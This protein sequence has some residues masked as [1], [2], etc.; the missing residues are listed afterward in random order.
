MR[1]TV[2]RAGLIGVGL[3]LPVSALAGEE[4]GNGAAIVVTGRGLDEAPAS[5]A[6]DSQVLGRAEIDRAPSGRIEDVLGQVAGFQQFRRSDSRSTNPSAQGVTLRAL[7]GN[8]AARTLVLLDGVPLADPM[9]GSVPLAAIDPER[10]GAIRVTRGGGSGAFGAGA[11]AG[12]IALESADADTLGRFRGEVLV[13]DRGETSLSGGIAPKLGA[14][15]ADISARWD[16]GAGFWTTP[17][18]QRVPASAKAAYDSW[19][20]S[21]RAVAPLAPDVE[22]QARGLVF[23]DHRT[24]RFVGANSHSFGED[25]S[26]RLVGRGPWQFDVLGYVQARGFSNVVIASSSTVRPLLSLNQ[27]STPSTGLGAKA[28]IR[29]PLGSAQLLRMGVDWRRAEGS[30]WEDSYFPASGVLKEHHHAGGRNDDVGFFAE[31][32]VTLGALVLTAGGRADRW[33][34][35]DGYVQ[36]TSPAGAPISPA[37]GGFILPSGDRAGWAFSGRGGAV[38]RAVP[39]LSLRASAYSGF[40]QP[41]LNE[42]YRT[43]VVSPVTTRNNPNLI[44]EVLK[45]YEAGVDVTALPGVTLRATAFYNRVEH[46]IANVT[47]GTNLQ[48]RQ[49]VRAIRAR[50]VEAGAGLSL[51]RVSLEAS[52]ALTDAVVE[53]PGAAINGLRPAQTPKLA[54]NAALAWRPR[55][56]GREGWLVSAQL[57]QIGN[58]SEDDLNSSFLPAAT[59]LGAVVEAPLGHGLTLIARGENLGD[60]RVETRNLAGSI[61]LGAPRT[62]WLG[63]RA[64][65]R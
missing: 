1:R 36:Y 59:T 64:G 26:L 28:E 37:A 46:A 60:A 24:L 57:R 54:A 56:G 15:F 40:R 55:I 53:A 63:L 51:G 23:D 9:F 14:G 43:F 47:I 44:N 20:L 45:G 12:T 8:A 65:L 2:V 6:Y 39:N 17:V 7:G 16:R 58:Q 27:R 29:P 50:G 31:D 19:S 38:W 30:L 22:L 61:D 11:V 62:V 10:L 49:N 41:T 25:A 21:P 48:Q 18:D 52:L 3:T 4:Q 13:D 35:A 34:I 5:P 32:D 42:L 33:S